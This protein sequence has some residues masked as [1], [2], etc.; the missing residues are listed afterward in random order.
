MTS[1]FLAQRILA[2]S[3]FLFVAVV[4]LLV[5]SPAIDPPA[6]LKLLSGPNIVSLLTPIKE[7]ASVLLLSSSPSITSSFSTQEIPAPSTLLSS[8]VVEPS[9]PPAIQS[10]SLTSLLDPALESS[11]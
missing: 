9:I 10:T 7:T 3:T 8:A 4:E 5:P 2:P 11:A 1:R 6:T